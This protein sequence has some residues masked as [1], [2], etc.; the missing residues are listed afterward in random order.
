ML[1]K[2]TSHK[3]YEIGRRVLPGFLRE[4]LMR[5]LWKKEGRSVLKEEP[6]VNSSLVPTVSSTFPKENGG[7]PLRTVPG[8]IRASGELHTGAREVNNY[9]AVGLLPSPGSVPVVC[10]NTLQARARSS[11]QSPIVDEAFCLLS[12]DPR[13]R[14]GSWGLFSSLAVSQQALACL[15]LPSM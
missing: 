5:Q 4:T 10:R 8:G 2:N 3:C 11:C 12:Y 14:A 6:A 15:Y 13:L 7:K 9:E 1:L